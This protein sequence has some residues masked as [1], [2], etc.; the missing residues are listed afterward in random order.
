MATAVTS[1]I[2][3]EDDLE[4][5][6]LSR[7]S[8]KLSRDWQMNAIYKAR[9]TKRRVHIAPLMK[10]LRYCDLTSGY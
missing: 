8:A 3:E 1:S 10:G 5:T 9:D 4:A 2:N 6:Y 7:T